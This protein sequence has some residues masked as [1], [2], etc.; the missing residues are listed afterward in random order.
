MT[1]DFKDV[2]TFIS[3]T[4]AIVSVAYGIYHSRKT[5]YINAV[6]TSRIKYMENLRNY[7]AEFCGLALYYSLTEKNITDEK[8]KNQIREKFDRLRFVIKLHLNRK[9]I[10][11]MQ[12]I[13]KINSI[14]NFT[15]P[16]KYEE[17]KIELNKLTE[18]T[19]D[20]LSFEWAGI[21]KEASKGELNKWEKE[22]LK[23]EH[24]K[25]YG[26]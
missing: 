2:L 3:V 14:P 23:K 16:E 22:N 5:T 13:E 8:E 21:K 6:T 12:V 4:T 18:L 17:L 9:D 7:I 15:D 10:F 25:N 19:Q 20:V 1:P 24:L 11:D 26:K